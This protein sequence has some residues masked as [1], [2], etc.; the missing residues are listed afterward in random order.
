MGK[1]YFIKNIQGSL[2]FLLLLFI[3]PSMAQQAPLHGA[4]ATPLQTKIIL[5]NISDFPAKTELCIATIKEDSVNFIGLKLENDTII[6]CQNKNYLFEIG[7]ITKVFTSTLFASLVI[8]GVVKLEDSITQYLDF[9]PKQTQKGG[10]EITFLSLANHTSGLP[11]HPPNLV[12]LPYYKIEDPYAVFGK[13][14][15]EDYLKHKMKLKFPP[16][17]K[18][19]YSNLGVGILGYL[20][21]KSTGKSYKRMMEEEIFAI[22][23]MPNSALGEKYYSGKL[24]KGRD[25]K[26][27]IVPPAHFNAMLASGGILSTAEDLSNF[28]LANFSHDYVLDFQRTKTFSISKEMDVALGWHIMKSGNEREWYWH[29][30]AT[31]GYKAAML[32]DVENQKGVIILSNI[33]GFNP[34]MEKIDLLTLELMESLY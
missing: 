10:K 31:A 18:Y 30:G 19:E 9:S 7:A 6:Y 17:E 4:E 3:T 1:F 11:N 33:S 24:A 13:T 22:Y 21:A 26:G 34:I 20:L 14:Q 15:L 2:Y 25:K 8:G 27:F 5:E 28:V 32:M 16:G 23:H 12:K 29:N